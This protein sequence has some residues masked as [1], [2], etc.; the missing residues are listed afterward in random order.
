MVL[1]VQRVEGQVEA[2]GHWVELLLANP[3]E[4]Q[5][6]VRNEYMLL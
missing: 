3:G 6:K 5:Q 1:V 2:G 4:L